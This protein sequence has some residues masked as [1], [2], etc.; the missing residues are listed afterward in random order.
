MIRI[1]RIKDIE[2]KYEY[3]FVKVGNT[4]HALVINDPDNPEIRLVRNEETNMGDFI[5][6]AYRIQTGADI[7]FMNGGSIRADIGAGEIKYMDLIT[8]LPW[9]SEAGVIEVTGQQ[10]LDCLEMGARLAPEE[11]GGFIQPSGL[12][13]TIDTTMKSSVNVN[14]E[15]EFVSVDGEYRVKDVMV[16]E[17]PLDKDKTY[18][19]A[20]NRYY[21]EECGDGMTMFKGSKVISP[22]EGEE[23]TIDHDLVIDY[24]ASLDDVIG[25][26]Y[27]QAHGQG[28]ITLITEE[29]ADDT[30]EE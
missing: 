12:T 30:A 14:S 5:T 1:I 6:D 3:L 25:D 24:I 21:S 20:I 22:A 11:C 4:E 8:V 7:A 2:K 18:T 26:E 29:K 27:A 17:E 19:L 9:N 28:R 16:G 15:G 13:Y 23:W 10:I